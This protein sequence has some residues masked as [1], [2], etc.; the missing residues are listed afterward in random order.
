MGILPPDKAAEVRSRIKRALGITDKPRSTLTAFN[1][2]DDFDLVEVRK[3]AGTPARAR[4]GA[5]YIRTG[6]SRPKPV[7]NL[8]LRTIMKQYALMLL[9]GAVETTVKFALNPSPNATY[10]NRNANRDKVFAN[11]LLEADNDVHKGCELLVKKLALAG[12]DKQ[13]R[14]RQVDILCHMLLKQAMFGGYYNHLRALQRADGALP[15]GFYDQL[16]KRRPAPEIGE[17]DP[18]DVHPLAQDY[19]EEQP[20]PPIGLGTEYIDLSGFH[21]PIEMD[22]A[23]DLPTRV[24]SGLEDVRLIL[25]EIRKLHGF[26]SEERM[27]FFIEQDK[28]T[29]DWIRHNGSVDEALLAYGRKEA[30]R[31]AKSQQN[32]EKLYNKE[33]T[34]H[35]TA[36]ASMLKPDAPAN[37]TAAAPATN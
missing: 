4:N 37:G 30:E 23:P 24:A 9:A 33:A 16:Y 21:M 17:V 12:V 35:N 10:E 25:E 5:C 22:N 13:A 1:D 3:P 7:I 20:E 11:T 2:L 8:Q 6:A 36:V 14:A 31:R 26:K 28:K 19:R 15:D 32:L 34:Q 27:A 18:E 29:L